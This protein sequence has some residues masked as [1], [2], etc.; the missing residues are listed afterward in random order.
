MTQESDLAGRINAGAGSTLGMYLIG[1]GGLNS[2]LGAD[3]PRLVYRTG[4]TLQQ[5]ALN[6]SNPSLDTKLDNQLAELNVATRKQIVSDIQKQIADDVPLLPLVLPNSYTISRKA[7]FD[8]WYYTPGGIG[9]VVPS[10]L[11]K[12]VFITGQQ[13]GGLP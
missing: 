4:A 10:V 1:S 8:K 9:G 6:Y 5:R 7:A 13:V 11:N 3:Y 12:H 2:D